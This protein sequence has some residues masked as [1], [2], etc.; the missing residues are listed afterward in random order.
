MAPHTCTAKTILYLV[1]LLKADIC[2]A[3]TFATL[4]ST[5]PFSASHIVGGCDEETGTIWLLGGYV[6]YQYRSLTHVIGYD[7]ATDTFSEHDS[8]PVA[9]WTWDS[10]HVTINNTLYA[11][12]PFYEYLGAFD[13]ST[14][15]FDYPWND[16][17]IPAAP[18]KRCMT[19]FRDRYLIIIGGEDNTNGWGD[20][21]DEIH[22]YD[23]I[24]E[25]WFENVTTMTEARGLVACE[26]VNDY[27]YVIGG[28]YGEQSYSDSVQKLYVGDI[29]NTED[30]E[31]I[32][33]PP[34][35]QKLIGMKTVVNVEENEIYVIGKVYFRLMFDSLCI[36]AVYDLDWFP[37][38]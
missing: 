20:Y 31:W 4:D 6:Y 17:Q 25:Q 15:T 33:L 2:S 19:Q 26:V 9:L 23:M 11:L 14:V 18:E 10:E 28:E 36:I 12:N 21:S 32:E 16:L 38:E 8:L 22:I 7:I 24:D 34:L 13:M 30:Y 3:I 37:S 29:E 35:K 1:F 5:M 27:L